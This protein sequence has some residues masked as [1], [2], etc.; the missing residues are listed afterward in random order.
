MKFCAGLVLTVTNCVAPVRRLSAVT[1][2]S[3]S[4]PARLTP[5]TAGTGRPL[6]QPSSLL[7]AHLPLGATA[8]PSEKSPRLYWSPAGRTNRRSG[9]RVAPC[10]TGAAASPW[11]GG[12]AVAVRGAEY[13]ARHADREHDGP[14]E[15]TGSGSA[16]RACPADS[17]HDNAT[18][19]EKLDSRQETDNRRMRTYCGADKPVITRIE[20]SFDVIL[21]S[22][23]DHLVFTTRRRGRL[24]WR[25]ETCC[26]ARSP[27][28]NPPGN[29]QALRM[30]E[31]LRLNFSE[32]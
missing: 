25:P 16:T 14:D 12:A 7:A 19:C 13:A 27:W 17:S 15:P 20:C 28:A 32:D 26:P 22:H 11:S 30:L 8:R 23:V 29:N 3:G 2:S 6:P 31:P 10:G 18:L 4:V 1:P 24:R 9:R 21:R 5:D